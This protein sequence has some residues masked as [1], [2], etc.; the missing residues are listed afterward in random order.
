M[1]KE[2]LAGLIRTFVAFAA[3]YAVQKGFIDQSLVEP[4]IGGIVAI[5]VAVWSHTSKKVTAA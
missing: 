2:Q 1:T 4:I 3:G 5:G